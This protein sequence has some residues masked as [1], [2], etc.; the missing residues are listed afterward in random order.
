[1]TAV[2]PHR[3]ATFV[4][5]PQRRPGLVL[6]PAR[7]RAVRRRVGDGHRGRHLRG[8]VEQPRHQQPRHDARG[9][10]VVQPGRLDGGTLPADVIGELTRHVPI[11]TVAN[12]AN[13]PQPAVS[14]VDATIGST[15]VDRTDG[16]LDIGPATAPASAAA[17]TA[18]SRN[19]RTA[20]AWPRP[21]IRY[22]S[23]PTRHRVVSRAPAPSS[24]C[25]APAGRSATAPGTPTASAT[26][27]TPC[28]G[29]STSP[30][31]GTA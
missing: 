22:R 30:P 8:R 24:A 6:A 12:T 18:T 1:M 26:T 10:C 25:T 16:V 21:A 20:T 5:A 11:T 19:R 29:R 27:S 17:R 4:L 7:A 15:T 28:S 13:A 31:C 3:P 2:R 9:R 23:S 14:A